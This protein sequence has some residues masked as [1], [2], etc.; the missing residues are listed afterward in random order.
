[1]Q[2]Y[3]IHQPPAPPPAPRS[4]DDVRRLLAEA[5]IE[6]IREVDAGDW[7]TIEKY[8]GKIKELSEAAK[9]EA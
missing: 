5:L 4:D 6:K 9:K 2:K 3:T 1:M 7:E 8:L